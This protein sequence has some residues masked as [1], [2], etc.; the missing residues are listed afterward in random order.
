VGIAIAIVV[1]LVVGLGVAF[2]RMRPTPRPVDSPVALEGLFR[3]LVGSADPTAHL[4]VQIGKGPRSLQFHK[5]A[6]GTG[7]DEI[8]LLYPLVSWTE[9]YRGALT[10]VAEQFRY[11]A[12]VGR[13]ANG[14]DALVVHCGTDVRQAGEFA[15]A[16]LNKLYTPERVS[17]IKGFVL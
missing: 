5:R 15:W 10:A 17:D 7:G 3:Q 6:K 2:W 9:P 4:Y 11:G 1:A 16:S 8:V 13:G 12:A 14:Q